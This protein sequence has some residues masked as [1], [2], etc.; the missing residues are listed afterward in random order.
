MGCNSCN[1]NHETEVRQDGDPDRGCK[2]FE[3]PIFSELFGNTIR[4]GGVIL[5]EQALK[6]CHFR[7]GAKILDVGCGCGGTVEFIKNKYDF[8]P[9]GIDTSKLLLEKG[10]ARNPDLDLQEGDGEMLDFPSL[11]FHGVLMECVLSLIGNQ[12]EALHEAYCVLKKGGKLIVSDMYL[13]EPD[14]DF[15][16]ARKQKKME[17]KRKAHQHGECTDV[18]SKFVPEC[19]INGAFV[20]DE[21]FPLL[22]EAGFKVLLW[23]DKTRELKSFTANIIMRYGS[24]ED[25]FQSM[26]SNN[27]E[28]EKF[29]KAVKPKKLGYFLLVAEKI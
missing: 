9:I 5:T 1:E 23:E 21:L 12:L 11:S 7:K 25:F 28:A 19:C 26:L 3:N 27:D 16:A 20:Q 24:L 14:P 13:R 29:S 17:E 15:V 4:P 22:T 8:N 6:F 2:V 18:N 10:K